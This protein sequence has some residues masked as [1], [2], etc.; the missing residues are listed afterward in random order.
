MDPLYLW[1]VKSTNTGFM[2]AEGP[3]YLFLVHSGLII[4]HFLNISLYRP[5]I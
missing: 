4:L 3:L 5:C 2:D 1:R